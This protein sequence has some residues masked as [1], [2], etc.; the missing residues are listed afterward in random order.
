MLF[1]NQS[2]QHFPPPISIPNPRLMNAYFALQA[3]KQAITSDPNNFTANWNGPDVCHYNGVYCATAPDGSHTLTVA[4][5]DLNHANIAGC[6]PDELG[7]LTD[8]SLFH[9]NS[10]RFSGTIPASFINLHLLYELDVSNNQFSGPFPCVVLYLPSLKYLDIRFNEFNGDIPEQLFELE[11]DALFLNNNKFESSLPQNLGNSPLSVFVVANNNIRGCIPPSLAK[12]GGTLEELILSNLGLTDSL[13]QDI[14][15]LKGLKVLDLSFNQ[16]CGPLP[17]SI[18][19]MRNLEQLNVAHNKLSGQVPKSICSLRNLQNFTYSF[20][21]IAGEPP[22][23]I[24][25]P[26]KDDRSNC[27]PSRPLQRSPEECRS[28]YANP[29]NCGAITCSRS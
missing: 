20:N 24:M 27:I 3:W 11:L 26:A 28:F 18:G 5:I 17:E 7:L 22:V 6:L 13:R 4:G 9:L 2:H 19:E 8:L 14:G 21:Y 25:S 15:M 16:L 10:N 29:I 1:F 12:M 23:C